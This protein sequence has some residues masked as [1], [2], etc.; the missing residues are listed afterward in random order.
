MIAGW[1]FNVTEKELW[2]QKTADDA[3]SSVTL[4][5]CVNSCRLFHSAIGDFTSFLAA[6]GRIG[7]WVA[8]G[9]NHWTELNNLKKS[10]LV[11]ELV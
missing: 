4:F 10:C 2:N 3:C 5:A 9:H 7:F 6:H 11:H 1:R 8:G